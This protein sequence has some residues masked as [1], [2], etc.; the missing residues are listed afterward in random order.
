MSRILIDWEEDQ[1]E[2]RNNKMSEQKKEDKKGSQRES[3]WQQ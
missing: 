1:A 2:D 3:V